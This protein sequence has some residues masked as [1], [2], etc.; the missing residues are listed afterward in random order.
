MRK[1]QCLWA[2]EPYE[3]QSCCLFTKRLCLEVKGNL[4]RVT[5]GYEATG[6]TFP[7]NRAKLTRSNAKFVKNKQFHWRLVYYSEFGHLKIGAK[8]P[9]T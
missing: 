8:E 4:L 2:E 3:V 7:L 5:H 1:A 9:T 6:L